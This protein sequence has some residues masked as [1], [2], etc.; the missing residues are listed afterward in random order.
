MLQVGTVCGFARLIAGFFLD[1]QR[2]KKQVFCQR[3]VSLINGVEGS[4]R[5]IGRREFTPQ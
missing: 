1:S 5:Q 3:K 4:S 2:S